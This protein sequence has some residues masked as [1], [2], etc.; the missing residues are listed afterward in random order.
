MNNLI[1]FWNRYIIGKRDTR[2]RRLNGQ[3]A[4]IKTVRRVVVH[5]FLHGDYF[6][7]L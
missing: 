3:Y 2:V 5:D 1:K 4:K 7:E 6:I